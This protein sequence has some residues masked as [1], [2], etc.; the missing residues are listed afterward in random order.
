MKINSICPS[1]GTQNANKL[2][3]PNSVQKKDFGYN[4]GYSVIS[5]GKGN[6]NQAIMYGVEVPPY[7]KAGGVATV[8]QDFRALRISDSDPVVT[9]AMKNSYDFYN[10][11]NKVIVDPIYNGFITYDKDGL[12]KNVE[13]PKIPA[14]LPDDNPLKKYE[15]HYF[16]TTNENISKYKN[17]YDFIKNEKLEIAN[18]KDKGVKGNVFILDDVTGHETKI[19]FGGLEES[20]RLS[21]FRSRLITASARIE[22]YFVPSRHFVTEIASESLSWRSKK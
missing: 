16:Q 7:N 4:S 9:N 15:G 20:E 13:I 5:F 11:S 2:T 18:I 19:D 17:I 6:K 1:Y 22:P 3:R 12:I 8:M 14:G 21:L 10:Q